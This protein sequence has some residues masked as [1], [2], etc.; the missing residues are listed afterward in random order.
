MKTTYSWTH[1]RP[2]ALGMDDGG[3]K[4]I[5]RL[6]RE[7]TKTMHRTVEQAFEDSF[8][9]AFIPGERDEGPEA[10]AVFAQL[11]KLRRELEWTVTYVDTSRHTTASRCDHLRRE[12]TIFL[13]AAFDPA[14]PRDAFNVLHEFCHAWLAERIGPLFASSV[15]RPVS[16]DDSISITE[17][18]H[19]LMV[20][21]LIGA[22]EWFADSLQR[23]HCPAYFDHVLAERID[24]RLSENGKVD[25][26]RRGL[27]LLMAEAFLYLNRQWSWECDAQ[28]MAGCL[29]EFAPSRPTQ[30]ALHD[31]WSDL[32]KIHAPHLASLFRL[33]PMHGNTLH[34]AGTKSMGVCALFIVPR[35][36]HETQS[37]ELRCRASGR[38]PRQ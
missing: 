12:H 5:A 36:L 23:N 27:G 7:G 16:G 11:G 29:L 37:A 32:V 2:S 28:A 6:C 26:E 35:Q 33:Q 14:N 15:I 31:L 25:P 38:H 34:R 1:A 3:V 30:Q 9:N 13:P 24:I 10:D 8:Q 17:L 18:D 21:Q 20:Q 4:H 22:V 19:W